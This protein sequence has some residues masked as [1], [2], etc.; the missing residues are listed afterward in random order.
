MVGEWVARSLVENSSLL[1]ECIGSTFRM[2]SYSVPPL[3]FQYD[4]DN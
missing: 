2:T 4:H 1:K 3:F